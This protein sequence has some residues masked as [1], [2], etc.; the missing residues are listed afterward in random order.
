[1]CTF[2]LLKKSNGTITSFT[3]SRTNLNTWVSHIVFGLV[4]AYAFV[5]GDLHLSIIFILSVF[6]SDS[7][8][9]FCPRLSDSFSSSEYSK[10]FSSFHCEVALAASTEFYRSNPIIQPCK[11]S[12][13][14]GKWYVSGG[15][16]SWKRSQRFSFQPSPASWRYPFPMKKEL[17][18]ITISLMTRL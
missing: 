10:L 1:M 2:D 5:S 17:G 15:K 16:Y 11:T 12:V 8:E 7:I 14:S 9:S 13:A 3:S 4:C 6:L 18:R